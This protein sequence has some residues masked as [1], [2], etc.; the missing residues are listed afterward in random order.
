[1]ASSPREENRI[2]GL[3]AKSDADNTPVIIEADPA[4]KR[5]KV[6]ATITGSITTATDILK[7]L[8][9]DTTTTNV[10][11]IGEAALGTATSAASWRIKKI[12]ESGSP[13]S[14]T[15]SSATSIYDNRATSV[16]YT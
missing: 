15:W 14:I 6:N 7:K 13:V 1:M 16:V 10:T 2:P 4:T 5:L 11:Y 12:D 8:I 3:V 9:D